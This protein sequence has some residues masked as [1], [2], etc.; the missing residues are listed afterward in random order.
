[1]ATKCEICENNEIKY[2]PYPIENEIYI[3]ITCFF[4]KEGISV[5]SLCKKYY[6]GKDIDD[7][8]LI[9]PDKYKEI[10]HS[11]TTGPP[12]CRKCMT[13]NMRD[14]YKN[15]DKFILCNNCFQDSC[16]ECNKNNICSVCELPLNTHDENTHD[17]NTHDDNIYNDNYQI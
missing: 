1:M 17:E 14:Q 6:Y 11:L 16:N 15:I 5:C 13:I 12:Q 8:Y 7:D 10:S 4:C 2:L 9:I 3:N